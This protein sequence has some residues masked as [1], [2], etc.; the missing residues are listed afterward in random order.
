MQRARCYTCYNQAVT[1]SGFSVS[2]EIQQLKENPHETCHV[3]VDDGKAVSHC[4]NFCGDC[5]AR[6]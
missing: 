5:D 2:A 3:Y 6:S 1:P 4:N